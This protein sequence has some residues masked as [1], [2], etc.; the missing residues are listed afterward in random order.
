[1]TVWQPI[2]KQKKTILDK[3]PANFNMNRSIPFSF[4][5]GFIQIKGWTAANGFYILLDV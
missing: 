3:L 4:K 2:K 1:V 5:I